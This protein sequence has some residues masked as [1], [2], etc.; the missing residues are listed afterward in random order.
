MPMCNI[1]WRSKRCRVMPTFLLMY[2]LVT[3][4][5]LTAPIG[6]MVIGLVWLDP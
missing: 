6:Y 5:P 4:R 1:R 2:F 3:R